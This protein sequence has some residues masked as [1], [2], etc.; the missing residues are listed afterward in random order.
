MNC[1]STG[2][3]L[4][5]VLLLI[6]ITERTGELVLESG[7]NI[8]T[9]IFHNGKILQAF[10]PYSRAIGD[11]LVEDGII[12][13]T[14]LIETLQEQKKT[15]VS[16]IGALF[17]KTGKVSFE[18]IEMMVHEQIRQSIKEFTTWQKMGFSFLEKEIAPYDT[19]HLPINEFIPPQTLKSALHFF[20]M[21][22]GPLDKP[23]A[24]TR[25]SSPV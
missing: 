14:E 15:A 4:Q 3:P 8:G 9:I 18:V 2:F 1:E 7:N 19:I 13:E 12:T 25:A 22:S 6:G 5:D 23:A 10:S 24:A 17:L 11:L 16:P 20:S 21:M